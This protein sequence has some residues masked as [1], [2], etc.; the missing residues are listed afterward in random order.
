MHE[1][2]LA[3]DILR[4]IQQ[5]HAAP[6]AASRAGMDSR[7]RGNDKRTIKVRLG[8]NRFTHLEELKELLAQISK[9]T[10]IEGVQIDF[11]IVPLKAVCKKCGT[12]FAAQQLSCKKCGASDIG[13]VSGDELEIIPS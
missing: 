2:H 5:C 3:E 7:F 8:E 11:E 12:E 1:L 9:G 13:I 10:E 6:D 4:K